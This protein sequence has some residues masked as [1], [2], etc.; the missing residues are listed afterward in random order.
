MF[1][2]NKVAKVHPL[3]AVAE[4]MVQFMPAPLYS[5]PPTA[6]HPALKCEQES[7]PGCRI[8]VPCPG[9]AGDSDQL[10]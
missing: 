9:I 6:I 5:L 3:G 1:H 4:G 7:A 2:G 8:P 10:A